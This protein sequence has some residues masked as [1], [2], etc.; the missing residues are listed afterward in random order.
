MSKQQQTPEEIKTAMDAAALVAQAEL[1]Q[2]DTVNIHDV[3]VWLK[4][5][6]LQTGY[7]RLCRIL[8]KYA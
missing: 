7:K 8:L 5:H 6:Y 1:E 3:A 2:L 4:N